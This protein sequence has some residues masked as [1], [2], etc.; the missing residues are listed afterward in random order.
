M[1]NLIGDLRFSVRNIFKN[2]GFSLAVALILALAMGPNTVIFSLLDAII[3]HPGPYKDAESLLVLNEVDNQAKS[4]LPVSYPNFEDWRRM[5]RSFSHMAAYRT[6]FFNLKEAESVER[7]MTTSVSL[8]FFPALGVSPIHGRTLAPHDFQPG[9]PKAVVISHGYWERRFAARPDICGTEVLVDGQAGLIVGVM[10]RNFRSFSLQGRGAGMWA[11]ING[12]DELKDRSKALVEVV[13][14]PRDGVSAEAARGEME[15]IASRL[16]SQYPESNSGRGI[17]VQ[18]IRQLWLST[19]GPAPRVL[20]LLVLAV[21]LVACANVANLLLANGVGRKKEIAL[22]RVLGATRLRLVDQLLTES[23]VLGIL[24][25]GAALIFAYWALELVNRF[26][27]DI[28]L[29]L[30]IERF[31]LDWT[32]VK[33][34]LVLG[35]VTGMVFGVIPAFRNSKVNLNIA[36]KEGGASSRTGTRKSRL[37]RI[38]VVSELTVACILLF[39]VC[40]YIRTYAGMM[41]LVEDPGFRIERV[42]TGNLSVAEQRF[43]TS[44]SRAQFFSRVL[45]NLQGLAGVESAG[46]TSTVPGV[47]SPAR[48]K[49]TLGKVDSSLPPEKLPGNWVDYRVVSPG[50][51]QALQIPLVTGRT[52]NDFDDDRAPSVAMVNQRAASEYWKGK[53]PVGEVIS[54]NGKAHT[55]IGVM[56]DVATAMRSSNRQPTEVAVSY[57]QDCPVTMHCLIY[58]QRSPESL[59]P[60]ARAAVHAIGPDEAASNFQSMG[61]FIDDAMIG[62]RFVTGLMASFALLGVLIA[63]AGVYGIMSHFASLKTAEIGIRMALGARQTDVLRQIMREGTTLVLFGLGIGLV[64]SVLLSRVLPTVMFGT[65]TVSPAVYGFVVLVLATVA[66]AACYLP[67]RRASRVDPMVALRSE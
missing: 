50:Y 55:V 48:A 57:R 14:R 60:D 3:F 12:S 1:R 38:L 27:G 19:V 9:S 34:A 53:S 65:V 62:N 22:R 26:S 2:L 10:P 64:F 25:A 17:R 36:L 20:S 46:L 8:D 47:Y 40:V 15:V 32:S 21:L 49:M 30:G 6:E 23:L 13:A 52:F 54:I 59:I 31:E 61:Q 43:Q 58:G 66:I 28:F 29:G 67:A 56:G 24:G 37:A 4:L 45:G 39:T 11:A 44:V 7:V 41:R 51:F 63:A 42:L 35:V 33:F 5:S 16:A 18:T